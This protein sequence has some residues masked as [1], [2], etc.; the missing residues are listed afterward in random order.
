MSGLEIGFWLLVILLLLN[1]YMKTQYLGLWVGGS[2][3]PVHLERDGL[4]G[5]KF[6]RYE[7]TKVPNMPV[8]T[9]KRSSNWAGIPGM[10]FTPVFGITDFDNVNAAGVA[11]NNTNIKRVGNSLV[12]TKTV[13]AAVQVTSY[14]AAV[15]QPPVVQVA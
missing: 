15:L 14:D 8:L 6:V 12:V 13:N 4:F 7:L 3:G 9:Y 11:I 1:E 5:V 10:K 2:N